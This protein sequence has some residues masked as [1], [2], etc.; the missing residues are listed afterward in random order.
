M[1]WLK[2]QQTQFIT[3][4]PFALPPLISIA[5]GAASVALNGTTTL[6]FTITNPNVDVGLTGV[7]FVDNLPAGLVVGPVPGVV[8]ACTAGTVTAVAGASQISYFGG[9]LLAGASCT[10]TVT[11][12]GTSAGLKHNQ[13]DPITARESGQ[14]L[15]SNIAD[16]TVSAVACV[17]TLSGSLLLGGAPTRTIQIAVDA[18]LDNAYITYSVFAGVNANFR[19]YDV[20]NPAAP[21]FLGVLAADGVHDSF[22]ALCLLGNSA[23]AGSSGPGAAGITSI[24]IAVPAAPA[25]LQNL[26]RAFPLGTVVESMTAVGTVLYLVDNASAFSLIDITAPAAMAVLADYDFFSDFPINTVAPTSI[27][28]VG[29]IAYI[30]TYDQVT[31]EALLAIYN[32]TAPLA[33]TQTSVTTVS[34][35]ITA[36]PRRSGLQVVGTT[37]YT[38]SDDKFVI[39]DVTNPA[40]PVILSTTTIVGDNVSQAAL[41]PLFVNS[42]GTRAFILNEQTRSM[43]T[44]DVTNPAAPLLI[45]T[46]ATHA[47]SSPASTV[48]SDG[49]VYVA[50]TEAPAGSTEGWLEIF[51]YSACGGTAAPVAAAFMLGTSLKIVTL[52]PIAFGSS[53]PTV[54]SNSENT[55]TI[56]SSNNA[57]YFS[58]KAPDTD[59]RLQVFDCTD[60]ALPVEIA[61]IAAL[62]SNAGYLAAVRNNILWV[63][64][65]APA[66]SLAPN[67]LR[68]FN[69]ANPAAPALLATYDLAAGFALPQ[70]NMTACMVDS[71]GFIYISAN[72]TGIGD[73]T[74][75]IYNGTNPLA[76]TQQSVTPI[77]AIP[78]GSI[79]IALDFPLLFVLSVASQ[80]EI[81]NVTSPAAP[82]LLGTL[83]GLG[84]AID[85][86]PVPDAGFLF[87]TARSPVDKNIRI[88]D[89]STPAAP[90]LVASPAPA[91]VVQR[92]TGG[93]A[94]D[95]GL[96]VLACLET[97][98]GPLKAQVYDTANA[99]LG[100]LALLGEANFN[101]TASGFTPIF[102][103]N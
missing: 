24:N 60:R 75:G 87:L 81:Y 3:Q 80:L 42:A 39:L 36:G 44:Y 89:V 50:E 14:G 38:V 15:A 19:S 90:V 66:G 49:L 10:I 96:L 46:Q 101:A 18:A 51:D 97:A 70:T 61:N 62:Q 23:F 53:T 29:A 85:M 56:D 73:Q 12:Q 48:G 45:G 41:Q 64:C 94:V 7:A 93:I 20:T 63:V 35:A 21:A 8:D 43:Y 103:A 82:A 30:L 74:V 84:N 68:A 91:G 69:V 5:F 79:I 34:S 76:V 98:I 83:L 33:V 65:N 31:P 9:T 37:A 13:T 58:Q 102:M 88:V 1:T 28:V 86:S 4:A 6:V 78:F 52:D 95:N 47:T 17:I 71:S 25:R 57:Y 16:L 40:A 59:S 72:A 77:T 55:L 11:V 92:N 27:V 26:T 100:T 2:H 54:S 32:V 67:S 22:Q 99:G